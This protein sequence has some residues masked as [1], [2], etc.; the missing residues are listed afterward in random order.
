MGCTCPTPSTDVEMCSLVFMRSQQ[1]EW[2]LSLQSVTG[3]LVMEVSVLYGLAT[4]SLT[5]LQLG[6]EQHKFSVFKGLGAVQCVVSYSFIWDTLKYF[7]LRTLKRGADLR[8]LVLQMP[9]ATFED[10]Y[11]NTQKKGWVGKI[12]DPQPS[13]LREDGFHQKRDA[14]VVRWR[15]WTFWSKPETSVQGKGIR[16]T[17]TEETASTR[18]LGSLQCIH[19]GKLARPSKL[20]RVPSPLCPGQFG[21]RTSRVKA[22]VSANLHIPE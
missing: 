3:M 9:Q 8:F 21:Q 6:Y 11:T 20:T 10:L 14:E 22:S 19:C 1:R 16:E 12:T 2:R 7:P 17:F 15:S 18:M 13:D 5:M 4:E